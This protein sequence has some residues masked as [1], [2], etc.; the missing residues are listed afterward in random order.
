[1]YIVIKNL[2]VNKNE[3]HRVV[4]SNVTTLTT[5]LRE[6]KELP[7]TLLEVEDFSPSEGCEKAWTSSSC[8]PAI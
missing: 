6:P 8:W 3:G 2:N 5:N 4:A 7:D 1:M